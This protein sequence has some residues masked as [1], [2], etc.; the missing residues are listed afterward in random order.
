MEHPI[1][2]WIIRGIPPISGTPSYQKCFPQSLLT[3]VI[4]IPI[5]KMVVPTSSHILYF[6]LFHFQVNRYIS[7]FFLIFHEFSWHFHDISDW[8]PTAQIHLPLS[9]HFHPKTMAL[10]FFLSRTPSSRSG[11]EICASDADGTA[12]EKALGNLSEISVGM[13]YFAMNIGIWEIRASRE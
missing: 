1:K 6:H 12:A 10:C 8:F 4:P 2:I 7:W 5:S 9:I 3:G 11:M 13:G